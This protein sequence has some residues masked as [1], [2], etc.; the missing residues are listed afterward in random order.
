ML[1]HMPRPPFYWAEVDRTG[2][3][4]PRSNTNSFT[5][6]FQDVYYF[7]LENKIL[8]IAAGK[9]IDVIWIYDENSLVAH[10][11]FSYEQRTQSCR[12]C[13]SQYPTNGLGV[14]RKLRWHT[15]RTADSNW[16]KRYSIQCGVVLSNKSWRER[17]TREKIWSYGIYLPKY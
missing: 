12:L 16:P 7:W 15:A 5:I 6:S 11:Y 2:H 4:T 13:F 8:F 14:R 17:S 10:Q 3:S 9:M 1:Y